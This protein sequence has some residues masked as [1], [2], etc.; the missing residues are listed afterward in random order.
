MEVEV[1]YISRGGN[2][3]KVADAIAKAADTKARDLG[4]TV[5]APV[6]LLFIGGAMYAFGL[7]ESLVEY[8]EGLDT[9]LIKAAAVFGTS[10]MVNG[11]KKIVSLLKKK[12][13]RVIDENFYCRGEFLK[14]HKGRPDES[15]LEKATAFAERAIAGLG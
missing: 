11:N 8:I 10:A 9:A 12:G 3:K 5:K 15:D 2:T 13:I 7:D 6:D 14:T 1:R 4:E